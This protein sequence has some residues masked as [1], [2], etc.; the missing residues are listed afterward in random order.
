MDETK[1]PQTEP[2]ED[3][4]KLRPDEGQLRALG[5][6]LMSD[7]SIYESDRKIA[8]LRWTRN[9]RQFLGQYDSEVAIPNDRSKAYPRLTRI[10]CVS[11]VA[12]LMNLLFP[13][14]EKNWGVE[15]SPVPNLSV[16]DLQLVL[17]QLQANPEQELTDDAITDAV[18]EFA[19]KRASNLET[20]IADQLTELG[21]A[22]MV[23]YVQLCKRVLMSGV[24]YGMGVLKGPMARSRT[25]RR[26]KLDPAQK[27][28]VPTDE[29]V[30]V[31]QFEFVP[32]WDYYPDMTAKYLHQM[33]GQFQRMVMSRTQLRELANNSEFF[34]KK[35]NQYLKDHQTGNYKAKQH[36]QELKTM[37]VAV[38]SQVADGRK[39]EILVW[40]GGLSGHYLKG[41][42]IDIPDN[43]LHEMIGA[44]VWVLDSVVIR[45]TLNPWLIV[46]EERPI[47]SYH[48]FVFEEDDT[49]L[50]GNGLPAVMRD[51]QLGVAATARM[52]LDNAGVV[53]G[54]NV[55]VNTALL[56]P[57]TDT[58]TI[59]AY[60][61]WERD[62]E[63]PATINVPAV[64]SIS[65]DSHI[66]ELLKVNDL[67]KGFADAETFVS[68]A[69]GGDMQKGPSEPFRTAAGASMIRGEAALPFKD[70]VRN[71][72]VFT[73]S[74]IGALVMFNKHFNGKPSVK[75]DF[76]PVARG[77]TSL[78]A[79][80]VRGMAADEFA[81]SLTPGESLY[82]DWR[83]LAKERVAVRDMDTSVLVDDAEAKRREDA[84]AEQQSQQN[85]QMERMFEAT[86][87][88]TLA[89]AVKNLT[90][91]DKN[92][93]TADASNY[94]TILDGLEKG[95]TPKDIAEV[96]EGVSEGIPD[97]MLTMTELQ[98]PEPVV[99]DKSPSKDK[100]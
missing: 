40:D 8:E 24:L 26:W 5:Q 21:G 22:K 55:E 80:E 52:M 71:F 74:V 27:K 39:Y 92:A 54:P 13:S 78:I 10:K 45:A 32:L 87:R 93:A 9:L 86:L 81:R 16:E 34:G 66:D 85:E 61:V 1:L 15:A 25:Q 97:G 56:T 57:N 90:Q 67:F 18:R 35:I 70:V 51:S 28:V 72:D 79:K 38:N 3:A 31:P 63:S 19:K 98:H 73:E 64:R 46:G 91:A 76:Q 75:G 7:F 14:S 96:R 95:A 42:G 6:K 94:N 65:F 89:E 36:E 33:D 53:C 99:E 44:V 4:P 100:E 41:C 83:K 48:H 30:L 47:P 12:R 49:S 60:K 59:H 69:T 43:K 11:M 29:V 62:D 68:P 88:K 17:D 23:S 82:V 2:V 58:T 20:E 77:S 50:M 37:G 84:Q